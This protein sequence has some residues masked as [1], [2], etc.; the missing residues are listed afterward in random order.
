MPLQFPFLASLTQWCRGHDRL[1]RDHTA[2]MEDII[3]CYWTR[4]W[5]GPQHSK[6]SLELCDGK[7]SLQLSTG[8]GEAL[9]ASF[10]YLGSHMYITR[11]NISGYGASPPTSKSKRHTALELEITINHLQ[12]KIKI[13]VGPRRVRNYGT[14]YMGLE[15][16][17]LQLLVRMPQGKDWTKGTQPPSHTCLPERHS[18]FPTFSLL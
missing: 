8:P 4:T 18:I 9:A 14:S 15:M 3:E 6:N 13:R 10:E 2:P 11:P 5:L 12:F 17:A 1:I 7:R 16:N